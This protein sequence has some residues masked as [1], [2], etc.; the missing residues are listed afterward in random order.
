MI[1]K[2]L[3][4]F[5]K[6]AKTS[7]GERRD[8]K[9]TT[10]N[11]PSTPLTWRSFSASALARLRVAFSCDN[12]VATYCTSRD[13]WNRY[14]R[15]PR[16]TRQNPNATWGDRLPGKKDNGKLKLGCWNKNLTKC[17]QQQKKTYTHK[18]P[19]VDLLWIG[20][21]TGLRKTKR[22]TDLSRARKH[23]L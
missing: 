13:N 2:P 19:G 14:L 21:Q 8:T 12:E 16:V 3:H 7:P 1:R 23:F 11:F 22:R 5:S 20:N 6:F 18:K 4:Q 9:T 17:P 15:S 10:P